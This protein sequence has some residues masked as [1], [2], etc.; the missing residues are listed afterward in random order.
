M[1][2]TVVGAGDTAVGEKGKEKSLRPWSVRALPLL[3]QYT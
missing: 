3:P 1:P 2:G